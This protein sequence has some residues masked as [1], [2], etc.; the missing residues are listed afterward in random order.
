MTRHIADTRPRG[1]LRL[2]ARVAGWLIFPLYVAGMCTS[3]LLER[4]AGIPG[5]HPMENAVLWVGFGAFAAVGALLVAR[6][7]TNLIGWIMAT[8]GLIVGLFPAGDSYAG[9]VM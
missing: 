3:Y 7:P 2:L 1:W 5:G 6:R 9:Y 4:S 8:V